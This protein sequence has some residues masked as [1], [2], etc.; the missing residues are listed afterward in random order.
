MD[1]KGTQNWKNHRESRDEL[2]SKHSIFIFD[3]AGHFLT[4]HQYLEISD[5]YWTHMRFIK[6]VPK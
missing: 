3:I 2:H 1:L 4:R 6:Q 5:V